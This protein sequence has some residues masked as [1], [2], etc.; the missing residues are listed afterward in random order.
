MKIKSAKF[1]Q[2]VEIPS[3]KVDNHD[4][5]AHINDRNHDITLEGNLIKIKH[6]A[7]GNVVYVTI[8]NTQYLRAADE[9]LDTKP[10]PSVK[11]DNKPKQK[12]D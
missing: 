12:Q 8:F 9:Q 11:S 2:T 4:V 3:N 6:R 7:S 1:F 5:S 10:A